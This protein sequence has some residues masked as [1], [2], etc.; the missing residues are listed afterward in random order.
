M[1]ADTLEIRYLATLN[2]DTYCMSP[3]RRIV[4]NIIATYGRSLYALVCG[5]FISRWVLSAAVEKS[6][7]GLYGVVGGMMSIE[8]L[9]CAMRR[10]R[11]GIAAVEDDMRQTYTVKHIR[12]GLT[13]L[14]FGNGESEFNNR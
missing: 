9:A 11:G 13:L 14:S 2:L 5:L 3:N 7:F 10:G 8:M 1:E 4:L 12:K 6:E